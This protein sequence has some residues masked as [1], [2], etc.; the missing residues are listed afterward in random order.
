MK[1]FITITVRLSQITTVMKLDFPPL[2]KLIWKH[3]FFSV[4]PWKCPDKAV[5]KTTTAQILIKVHQSFI[6]IMVQRKL[7]VDHT[8]E[9]DIKNT[10]FGT[11]FWL[12][13]GQDI[14]KGEYWK[15]PDK[16]VNKTITAQILK[17]KDENT[18]VSHHNNGIKK[19]K[20]RS[21]LRNWYKK[22]L[23]GTL[24]WLCTLQLTRLFTLIA[25]LRNKNS[26]LN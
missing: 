13:F 7:K 17:N 24:F 23:F 10:F 12:L 14:F 9:T 15:S 18:P 16:T 11:L 25:H 26:L 2:K 22:H 19:I 8:L 20:S 4:H 5:N 3:Q 6:I 1:I 21:Y